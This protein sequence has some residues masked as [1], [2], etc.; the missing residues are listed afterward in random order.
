MKSYAIVNED[1]LDLLRGLDD[2]SIDLVL[3]D[4]PY[5][6]GYDGGKG[7]D[8]AWDTEQDYL[9]WCKLWTAECVRVLK[10]NR[11]MYVWGTTKTDTFLKYKLDVLNSFDDIYYQSWIIWSYDWGGRTKKN[12]ARKHEDLLM[13]SKGKEFMFNKDD[14]R[15]PYILK[16]SVR[17]GK[18]LNP[19]G[20]IPTDVW[21]KNNHTTSKEYAGW[22]PTQKPLELLERIIKAHTN[23][24]DVVLD[25]F[26]GSG[27]TAIASINTN[28]EFIGCELDEEYFTKSMERINEL[29]GVNRFI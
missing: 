18:E 2:N 6:I 14:V 7:W 19:F 21:P 29:T 28:R 3:T 25:C 12:F 9:D 17:K 24:G 22:H 1:C 23:Q 4:P 15:I 11:C 10:P 16:K 27:S 5:Y 20:K 8:S 26:S 13:Y